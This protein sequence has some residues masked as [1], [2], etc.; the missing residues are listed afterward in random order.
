[1]TGKRHRIR[2]VR[3]DEFEGSA[4]NEKARA[5]PHWMIE[6]Y[7]AAIDDLGVAVECGLGFEVRVVVE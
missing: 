1:M 4:M 7:N 6:L 3:V 5:R 2:G